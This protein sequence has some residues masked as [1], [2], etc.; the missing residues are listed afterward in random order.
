MLR[1]VIVDDEPKAIQGLSWELSTFENDI[2]I[3]ETFTIA[4]K[5]IKF[6]NE[7][8]IDCLFL[9]IEMPTMDGFQLLEKLENKNFAIIITTAYNEYAIKAL[10][11]Q[12]ID[13]LLKPIDS[14]DLEAVS[15]THLT[16]PTN[17]E[18]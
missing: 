10:K 12:A 16:L 5:A 1:A 14:D 11:N 4:E 15:Y 13:Y 3:I 8:T 7:N 6:I 9:D 18:V 17:R 2:E